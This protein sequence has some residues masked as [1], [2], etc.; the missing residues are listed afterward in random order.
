[1]LEPTFARVLLKRPVAEKVGSILLPSEAA[2]KH[3]TLKCEVMAL[4]PTAEGVSVGDMV[5]I[6]QYAG[7]WLDE[8]GDPAPEG[9]YFIVQDE[10]IVAKVV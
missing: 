5:I 1:M 4:G 8:D 6:G 3:A 7:A 2:K 10:D 9:E